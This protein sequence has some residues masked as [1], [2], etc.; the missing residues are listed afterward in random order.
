RE[1]AR[2][3]FMDDDP[4]RWLQRANAF[5]RV[6]MQ[7]FSSTFVI[8]FED[9]F[10]SA[11]WNRIPRRGWHRKWNRHNLLFLDGHSADLP[12]R[13]DLGTRGPGWKTASGNDPADPW[14]WWNDPN[15]P[16]YEHRDIP[17]LAGH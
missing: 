5:L 12:T 14:A 17:P 7:R 4:P 9:P 1:W 2:G 11:Q 13:T 10:D 3:K 16:D 15:D 6:Q 8:A